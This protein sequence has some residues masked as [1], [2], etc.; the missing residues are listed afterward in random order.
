MKVRDYKVVE[1]VKVVDITFPYY[2]SRHR[3]WS[4]CKI[5]EKYY[6]HDNSI[7]ECLYVTHVTHGFS[8]PSEIKKQRIS[9]SSGMV[10][11]AILNILADYEDIC[12][13]DEYQ[14]H[15][16]ETLALLK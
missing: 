9:V 15:F 13:K 11:K 8:L 10:E 6:A 16:D 1:E 5:E 12:T 14:K 2:G 7:L 4:Y 3:K